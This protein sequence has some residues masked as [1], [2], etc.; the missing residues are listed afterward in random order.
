M[1]IFKRYWHY[2]THAAL[3]GIFDQGVIRLANK[4]VVEKEMPAVWFSSNPEWE[5]TVRKSIKDTGTG[6]EIGPFSR[7]DLL[8]HGFMPVR[9]ELNPEHIN[10]GIQLVGW[11]KYKQISGISKKFAK[12]LE[13]TAL[14]W[15]SNPKEWRASFKPV[16]IVD[17]CFIPECWN[18]EEWM[19]MVLK[20]GVI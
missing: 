1:Q 6:K 14:D 3:E 8:Q 7:D 20:K 11:K 2:T 5:E 13:K 9:L 4:F 17:N 19:A 15:G 18:G 12:S 16:P 10:N